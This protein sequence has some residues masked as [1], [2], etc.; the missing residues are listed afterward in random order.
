MFV[1]EP[2]KGMRDILPAEMEVREYLL[3]KLKKTT[4]TVEQ[5]FFVSIATL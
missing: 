3:A 1:K 5:L 2:T 4:A